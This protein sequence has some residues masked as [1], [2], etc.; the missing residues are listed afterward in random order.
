M[1][2]NM[3][4]VVVRGRARQER[5]EGSKWGL[6]CRACM[7]QRSF[8]GRMQKEVVGGGPEGVQL[9]FNSLGIQ[10]EHPIYKKRTVATPSKYQ[11]NQSNTL[12]VSPCYMFFNLV[13]IVA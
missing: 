2:A 10:G 1:L 11:T 9:S 12:M 13:R 3:G 4:Y 6:A 7:T 5:H 8:N